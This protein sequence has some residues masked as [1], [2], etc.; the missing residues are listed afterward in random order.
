MNTDP[1]FLLQDLILS[2]LGTLVQTPSGFAK[3]NCMMCHTLGHTPDTRKRFGIRFDNYTIAMNCFNCNFKAVWKIGEHLSRKFKSF[4]LEIGVSEKEIQKIAFG[5]LQYNKGLTKHFIQ[6]LK[7]NNLSFFNVSLPENCLSFPELINNNCLDSN[8][9]DCLQYAV[10]RDLPLDRLYW[11]PHLKFNRRVIVPFTHNSRIVGYTGRIIDKITNKKIPKYLGTE[12]DGYLFNLDMQDLSQK[13]IIVCEGVFDAL[14]I[15]AVSTLGQISKSQQARLQNTNKTIVL[16]PD[17]D[18]A[19]SEF[20]KVAIDRKW[21][22]SWPPWG[23]GIK[24]VNDAVCLYG[25]IA[26]V[27]SIMEN[28]TTDVFE[29]KLKRDMRVFNVR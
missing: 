3:T 27:Q 19:G 22:I 18:K 25:K 1:Y 14:P 10:N 23:S 12:Q 8:F 24:D 2:H 13:Y 15:Y 28:I 5:I 29:I 17:R 9:L 4:L 16:V 6:D 7:Y 20:I 21:A 26:T 11:T